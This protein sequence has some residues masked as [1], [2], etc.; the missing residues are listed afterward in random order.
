MPWRV[1]VGSMFTMFS[2]FIAFLL[3]YTI[4]GQPFYTNE[5]RPPFGRIALQPPATLLAIALLVLGLVLV[6]TGLKK[7]ETK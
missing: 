5:S 6:F 3:N 7:M 2:L 1:F 4:L